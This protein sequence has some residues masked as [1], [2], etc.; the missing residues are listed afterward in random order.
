M[1]GFRLLNPISGLQSLPEQDLCLNHCCTWYKVKPIT[2]LKRHWTEWQHRL[3]RKDRLI[4][5]YP[6]GSQRQCCLS[7]RCWQSQGT[8]LVGRVCAGRAVSINVGVL[9]ICRVFLIP[10]LPLVSNHHS[11]PSDVR[12]S[13]PLPT[14]KVAPAS[15]SHKKA[16]LLTGGIGHW[17]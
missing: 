9:F 14:W 11:R 5:H 16:D 15:H 2:S 3:C 8:W 17:S 13:T 1:Q 10:L 6:Q 4:C 12:L 7:S